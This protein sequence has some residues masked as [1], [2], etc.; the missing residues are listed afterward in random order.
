MS[1][2]IPIMIQNQLVPATTAML[3]QECRTHKTLPHKMEG[4]P[5]QQRTVERG[6]LGS[7]CEP[8]SRPTAQGPSARKPNP[9]CGKV[10]SGIR[11][12]LPLT[13]LPHGEFTPLKGLVAQ[14]GRVT[15]PKAHHERTATK[16]NIKRV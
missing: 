5:R 15:W 3:Q 12:P 1:G 14:L 16:D 2:V 11:A 7:V 13:W 4:N 6:G 8:V 10:A 9:R